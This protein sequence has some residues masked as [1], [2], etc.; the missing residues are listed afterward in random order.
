[1]ATVAAQFGISDVALAKQCRRADIPLPNRGYWARKQ[2]GKP[3]VQVVLPPRFPGA[4]DRIGRFGY[5]GHYFGAKWAE[6]FVEMVVPPVP[7]FDEEMSSIAERAAK[8]V[9]KVRFSRKFEPAHPLVQRL[10]AHDVERRAE[11]AKWGSAYYA[12]K[13]D[14]GI[15]RRRLLIVNALFQVAAGLGCRPLMSTSKY[16]QEG[17]RQLSIIVGESHIHFTIELF[18]SRQEPKT[19]H[20]RLAFGTVEGRTAAERTWGDNNE[21]PLEGQLTEILI[22]MLVDAEANYRKRLVEHRNWII[23]RKAAAEAELKKRKDE[24]GRKASELKNQLKG[25]RI[26]RLL[27]QAKA[28][29]RANRNRAY[30]ALALGHA[31]EPLRARAELA[32]WATWAREQADLIDP[33]KNGKI[34][35]AVGEHADSHTQLSSAGLS[36]VE[37]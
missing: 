28:L 36:P 18:K 14:T 12:P 23:E 7:T 16:E 20:L 11:Y 33:L 6:K 1:M 13:Y 30:V 26:G 21:A 22:G 5:R 31:A 2:A 37:I 24:A 10:L 17:E 15:E 34:A 19:E 9:G 4:S 27:S 35:E 25:E 32:Q 8:L 29:D 3:T